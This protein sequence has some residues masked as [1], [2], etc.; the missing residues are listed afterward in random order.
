MR[1]GILYAVC[2]YGMWG[3]LPVYWKL[4]KLV[5]A[6]ELIPHRFVWSFFLLAGFIVFRKR[7]QEFREKALRWQAL[8]FY[9][10]S[11]V[12]LS[13]NWLVYIWAVNANYIVET[14]LGYFIN[15]LVSVLLGVIVFRERLRIGQWA[16]VGLAAAG[17][18]YLTFVYGELPWIA[19][20]LALSFGFYGLVKKAAP[21]GPT[22]G[23]MLETG[24]LFVPALIYLFFVHSNG[25]GA[26]FQQG[27]WISLLLVG[28]GLVTAVPL[29]LFA[30]AARSIPLSVVGILQYIAPTLQFLI[31]VLVYGESFS[32]DRFI[33]FAIVWVALLVFAFEGVWFSQSPGAVRQPIDG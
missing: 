15:P 31:G 3:I 21:L 28:T 24:I 27:I 26:F 18:I 33:G 23:L 11:G 6:T 7:W 4:L 32:R 29:L 5:P 10:I 13:I 17:V 2:A 20:T 30:S 14:S 22:L 1:K 9:L 12:L 19:L 25:Q 8:R 16:P